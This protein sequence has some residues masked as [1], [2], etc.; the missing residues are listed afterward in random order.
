M[1]RPRLFAQA[2]NQA[3][4]PRRSAVITNESFEGGKKKQ[5]QDTAVNLFRSRSAGEF[6][7]HSFTSNLFHLPAA[8]TLTLEVNCQIRPVHVGVR[9]CVCGGAVSGADKRLLSRGVSISASVSVGNNSS[10]SQASFPAAPAE[11]GHRK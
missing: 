1:R 3:S 5:I 10:R 4:R 7:R 11:R 2:T 8:S 9:A 6:S